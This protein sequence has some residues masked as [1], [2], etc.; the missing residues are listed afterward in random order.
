MQ[1]LESASTGYGKCKYVLVHI[2]VEITVNL[3]Q[4][5]L[6]QLNKICIFLYLIVKS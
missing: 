2:F 5:R 3:C 6:K 1:V 4:T